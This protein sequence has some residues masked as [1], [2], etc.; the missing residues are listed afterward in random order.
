MHKEDNIFEKGITYLAKLSNKEKVLLFVTVFGIMYTLK[1][2]TDNQTPSFFIIALIIVIYTISNITS[3]D[4]KQAIESINKYID[5]IETVVVQHDTPQMIID[6]VYKLHKPIKNLRFV[7]GN[8][9]AAQVVYYLR[10][11][12]IYDKEMYLDFIIYL[13]FFLKLHFNI[14]IDKYDVQ[15]NFVILQDIRQELLNT[16][17]SYHFNIPKDSATFD[18]AD[19]DERL[20]VS[21]AKVQALTYRY[22]KIVH[23]KFK[24]QLAHISYKGTTG[25][26]PQKN[27]HYH[28]Y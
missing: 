7:K 24:K 10:F 27:N 9:E 8:K 15:T 13:E 22:V 25:V 21:I 20:R 12:N 14:M 4:K 11:L 19:L 17:Q 5:D 6:T 16:L 23:K 1:V 26:D 18:D 2:N 28:I 3:A